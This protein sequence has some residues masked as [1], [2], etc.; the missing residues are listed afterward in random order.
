MHASRSER[1][2]FRELRVGTGPAER[3]R[4][5]ARRLRSVLPTA[6]RHE[7]RLLRGQGFPVGFPGG[8]E[9][10]AEALH[11]N[12]LFRDA[13][14]PYGHCRDSG[15]CGLVEAGVATADEWKRLIR[16][17]AGFFSFDPDTRH[18]CMITVSAPWRDT[19]GPTWQLVAAMRRKIH[20][21]PERRQ[22]CRRN[23]VSGG[24]L[25]G[26][27]VLPGKGGGSIRRFWLYHPGRRASP[28]R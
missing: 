12:A 11:R 27:P 13:C 5:A 28:R 25:K 22:C 10:P 3:Q 2:F 1:L 18:Y 15:G 26:F 8:T 23:A 9:T 19:P 4:A 7:A 21:D 20:L 24:S 14:R 17:H 6:H 16:R